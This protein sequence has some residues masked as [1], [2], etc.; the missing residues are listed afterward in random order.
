MWVLNHQRVKKMTEYSFLDEQP[1]Q[2]IYESILACNNMLCHTS[3]LNCSTFV[4]SARLN[5]WWWRSVIC[6][7]RAYPDSTQVLESGQTSLSSL[8][9]VWSQQCCVGRRSSTVR[10]DLRWP[11]WSVTTKCSVL[12]H[13]H[14]SVHLKTHVT[15]TKTFS[16]ICP[17]NSLNYNVI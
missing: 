7:L 15:H 8:M 2:A 12:P 3:I 6:N 10:S 17:R 14:L 13:R 1:L 5:V 4:L 9:C 16:N 11:I